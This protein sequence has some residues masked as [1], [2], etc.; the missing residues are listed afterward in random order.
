MTNVE[1][2]YVGDTVEWDPWCRVHETHSGAVLLL[3]DL[4]YKFKKPVALGFLD[5]RDLRT[6]REVCAREVELNSRL[7]PDVYL[8]VGALS[9]PDA[10][11][12]EPAV[13]MR[14]LPDRFRLSHLARNGTLTTDCV[15][16]IAR[17]VASFHAGGRSDATVRASG[18]REALRRRWDDNLAEVADGAPPFVDRTLLG[19]I[20][21]LAHRYLDGRGDLFEERI[22]IGAVVDGHG[23]L[24]PD[25]TFCL[26]DGPRL[27]DCLEFADHLRH[28]DRLDDIAFLAMGLEE[29]G[30]DAAARRLVATWSQQVGDHAPAS[31]FHHYVAYR[32]FV[33][34]KVGCL[35]GA[36]LHGSAVE[37]VGR[38]LTLTSSH[39]RAAE[40]KMVLVG[41]P[42]GSGKSTLSAAIARELGMA[43][44]SSDRIRKELAGIDA[45]ESAAAPFGEGIYDVA[46]GRATYAELLDRARALLRHGESVVLDASWTRAEDRH[47]ATALAD[48]VTA[49]IVP[50]RCDVDEETAARR[51]RVRDSISDANGAVAAALRS[52]ADPWPGSFR[53]DTGRSLE[54]SVDDVCRLARVLPAPK[55]Q[56]SAG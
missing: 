25:D 2:R 49:A 3:G 12:D 17:L 9:R 21:E 8:G 44:L 16:Q 32:A 11:D 33:R 52:Q 42:P 53:I 15:E 5:F 23:D 6:R 50:L 1:S 51:I 38:Y 24:T 19:E 13:V 56:R 41:G 10:V 55:V 43:V 22:R 7:A 35:R 46:H 4:A 31:L 36:Q 18:S 34:A 30:A 47:A 28:V 54:A 14:R 40:V 29:L 20:A 48:D 27:L 26:P 37:E 45:R 39:L